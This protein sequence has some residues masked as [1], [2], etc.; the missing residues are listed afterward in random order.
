VIEVEERSYID[1]K[2]YNGLLEKFKDNMQETKQ[3]TYYFSGDKDFRL[4]IT[5]EYLQLWLKE[6][7]IHDDAREELIVKIDPKYKKEIL[8][9]LKS[10]GYEIE[11]KWFR[12]RC[13]TEYEGYDLTIDYSAGYGHIIEIESIIDNEDMIDETKGILRKMLE[14]LGI[15]I[16]LKQEFKDKYNDYKVNYYKYTKDIN[17]DEFL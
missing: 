9:M 3:I 1:E 7:N 2:T 10:L 12:R 14:D 16:S 8:L 4:M 13:E 15:N 17:E 5:K 6:G 11:I